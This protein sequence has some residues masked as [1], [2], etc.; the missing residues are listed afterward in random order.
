MNLEELM[1]RYADGDVEAF[2]ELHA[3]LRPRIVATLRRWL[4]ADDRID[5]AVQATLLTLHRSR[6]RYRRD[7]PVLPWVLTI[8]RNVAAPARDSRSS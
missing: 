1:E 8:A 7:E 6:A 4:T 2:E 5:D 3:R